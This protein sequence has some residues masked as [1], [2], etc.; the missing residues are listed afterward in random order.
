MAA[1]LQAPATGRN[2]A[3]SGR[4]GED[5]LLSHVALGNQASREVSFLGSRPTAVRVSSTSRIAR[6]T[7]G[8]EHNK[9][10]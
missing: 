7:H 5:P 9:E 4:S 6:T 2:L 1:K 10:Q 3:R 8:A